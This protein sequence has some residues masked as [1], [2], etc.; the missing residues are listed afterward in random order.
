MKSSS[1]KSSFAMRTSNDVEILVEED[2]LSVDRLTALFP[3]ARSI[4]KLMRKGILSPERDGEMRVCF[5]GVAVV[6]GRTFQMIPKIFKDSQDGIS[7]IMRQVIRA[8]RRY[9]RWKPSYHEETPYL[10][11]RVRHAD[12]SAIAIADWLIRDYLTGGIYRRF[13]DREEINGSGQIIWRRTIERTTPVLSSG[14]P[15]YIDA[16][17]RSSTGDR[18]H[19]VSR[20]HRQVVEEATREFGHLLGYAPVRLDHEPFE[21]FREMPSLATSN[22]RVRQEMRDSFTDRAMYLLPML[23]SWLSAYE[24]AVRN[25]LALYGVTAFYQIW[26]EVCS[27][28][29]GNERG[30]WQVHI[31]CPEWRSS[32]GDTQKAETFRPD[33][34]TRIKDGG[35]EHLLIADAK[36]YQLSMPPNLRGQPG[37]NDIAKQLWYERCLDPQARSEGLARTYNIFV[38]PGA[39]QNEIF[40]SDGSV[41]LRGLS[42]SVVKVKRLSGLHGLERY[43]DGTP[44]PMERVRDVVMADR[45]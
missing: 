21:P 7:P 13:R 38:M 24:S 32:T 8:L 20:L 35:C 23:L 11:P 2:V 33:I 31:P 26:E 9:A 37:I 43:A 36:Y 1:K 22:E 28:A 15:V 45:I 39:P 5:V 41:E 30:K 16:I 18:D 40:W 17:T 12:P 10:D 29:L 4:D 34:V 19:F 42:K 6:D 44:L 27:L 3:D 25:G 14:R